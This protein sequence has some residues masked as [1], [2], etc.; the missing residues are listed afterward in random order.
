MQQFLHDHYFIVFEW[1]LSVNGKIILYVL[2]I[3]LTILAILQIV[4]Y[5]IP[6]IPISVFFVDGD[7]WN[8]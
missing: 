3:M 2:T 1:I 6:N 8:G 5:T 7:P 4:L